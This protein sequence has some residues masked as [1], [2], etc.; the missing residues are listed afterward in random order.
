MSDSLP[1]LQDN[2][3][4]ENNV[5]ITTH[6]IEVARLLFGNTNGIVDISQIQ[7]YEQ[8]LNTDDNKKLY[9][10]TLYDRI[11]PREFSKETLRGIGI[12]VRN[13]IVKNVKF[14]VDENT[15]GL[16]KSAV[17]RT[18][19]FPSFW[20][21]DLT[22]EQSLQMDIFKEFPDLINATL[23]DKVQSWKGMR[24]KVLQSIRGHRNA[25]QTSIQCCVVEGE[26]F[27][28]HLITV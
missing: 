2:S 20:K 18:R 17:E 23:Y 22:R 15:C 11:S 24:E 5:N 8:T 19:N 16:S 7:T 14:I 10:I 13:N 25:I 3:Y 4:T 1:L 28:F 12:H 21:P 26:L 9:L 6:E 27:F